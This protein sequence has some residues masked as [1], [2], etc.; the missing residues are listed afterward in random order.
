MSQKKIKEVIEYLESIE[1][2]SLSDKA[3]KNL[4]ALNYE[5]ISVSKKID[6]EVQSA[7]LERDITN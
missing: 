4:R 5:L 7:I 2:D 6:K 1:I 3:L